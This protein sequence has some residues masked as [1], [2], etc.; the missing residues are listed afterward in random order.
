M[1]SFLGKKYLKITPPRLRAA[2]VTERARPRPPVFLLL[3]PVG[4]RCALPAQQ[5]FPVPSPPLLARLRINNSIVL[6]SE[7]CP[8]RR[9]TQT[10]QTVVQTAARSELI[11]SSRHFVLC[12]NIGRGYIE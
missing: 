12:G 9:D 8:K 5:F 11:N 2:P 4:E 7:S 3:R 10:L 6:A 1:T